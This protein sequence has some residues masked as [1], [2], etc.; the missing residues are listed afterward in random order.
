M[1]IKQTPYYQTYIRRYLLAEA[2][3]VSD[4]SAEV[5]GWGSLHHLI[6]GYLGRWWQ[7]KPGMHVLATAAIRT[8]ASQVVGAQH[9]SYMSMPAM[10]SVSTEPAVVP[11]TILDLA[12][13]VY[14]QER[15]LL[16]VACMEAGVEVTLG[17]LGHVELVQELALVALL[18]ETAKPMFAHDCP[19]SA[20][21]SEWT[22][23]A[24]VALHS[25]D[26]IVELANGS[27]GF[28]KEAVS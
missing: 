15:T 27:S 24:L 16:V 17:H 1:E 2:G 4:L 5:A 12:L 14:V 19:V 26:A 7:L 21:M 13:R 23:C 3:L 28:W 6:L 9:S 8:E 11:G 10:W 25:V 18:T 20:N 22:A